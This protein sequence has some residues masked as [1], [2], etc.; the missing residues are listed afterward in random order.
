MKKIIHIIL[1]CIL[2]FIMVGCGSTY[3]DCELIESNSDVEKIIRDMSNAENA[4]V[5]DMAENEQWR[6]YACTADGKSIYFLYAIK[7]ERGDFR[8]YSGGYDGRVSVHL[9]PCL[10]DDKG[11]PKWLGVISDGSVKQ[12]NIHNDISGDEITFELDKPGLAAYLFECDW[13]DYSCELVDETGNTVEYNEKEVIHAEIFPLEK[14]VIDGISITFGMKQSDVIAVLGAG[15]NARDA[16][17]YYESDL[18]ICYDENNCVEFVEFLGGSKGRVQPT[19]Y[20]ISPFSTKASE[21]VQVL[22][23]KNSGQVEGT[24]DGYDMAFIDISVGVY[25]EYIPADIKELKQQQISDEYSGLDL[26][27]EGI[28]AEYWD[29]IGA[30]VAGYYK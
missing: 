15:E 19:I 18:A 7:D 30:G 10:V 17:Y 4:K 23:D 8:N 25:R 14:V 28:S 22:Q 24:A 13:T 20:G 2:I 6:L 3:E 9:E 5:C 11:N 12:L 29:T 1:V 26:E 16:H 27:A 21:V